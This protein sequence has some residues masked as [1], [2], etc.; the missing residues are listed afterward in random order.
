M[1]ISTSY[2]YLVRTA[3]LRGAKWEE[4]DWENFVAH[5]CTAHEN[6]ITAYYSPL[7]TKPYI[8]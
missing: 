7:K 4:I 2:S 6:E 1:G 8:T 3:K 5:L